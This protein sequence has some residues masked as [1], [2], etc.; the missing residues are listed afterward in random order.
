M[1]LK[2]S[3]TCISLVPR[4]SIMLLFCVISVFY[5]EYEIAKKPSYNAEA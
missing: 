4:D 3:P 2:H 1:D 5:E